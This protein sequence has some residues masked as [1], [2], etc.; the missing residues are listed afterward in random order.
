[1]PIFVC[2]RS[3]EVLFDDEVRRL[4]ISSAEEV[5][6][7]LHNP[8]AQHSNSILDQLGFSSYKC[9]PSMIAASTVLY[10]EK[11]QKKNH[12]LDSNFAP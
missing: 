9:C 8:I 2:S 5:L 4:Q 6:Q 1:M 12:G 3:R 10:A 11:L 7:I